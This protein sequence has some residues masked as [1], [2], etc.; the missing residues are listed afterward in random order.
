MPHPPRHWLLYLCLSTA[1]LHAAFQSIRVLVSY[2]ILALGGDA[3]TIGAV[4]ALYAIVPLIAAV[5]MGRA[6]DRGHATAI[7]RSGIVVTTVGAG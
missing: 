3:T 2:R 5:R 1:L 7:L 6:V 4:T